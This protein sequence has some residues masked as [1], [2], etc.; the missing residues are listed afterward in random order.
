MKS[1]FEFILLVTATLLL[2]SLVEQSFGKKPFDDSPISQLKQT[3]PD[4][5]FMGS[6]ILETRIN[7]ELF[8][9]TLNKKVFMFQLGGAGMFH[10]Y[11]QLTNYI[12]PSKVKPINIFIF[13][14][15]HFAY[16]NIFTGQYRKIT[17]TLLHQDEPV[18]DLITKLNRTSLIH[19]I[20]D[21]IEIIYPIQ[22]FHDKALNLFKRIAVLPLFRADL[23]FFLHRLTVPFSR[24]VYSFDEQKNYNARQFYI[25]EINQIFALKNLRSVKYQTNTNEDPDFF[26]LSAQLKKSF[27]P[28]FL[29]N[30]KNAGLKLHFIQVKTRP[31]VT[32]ILERSPK[33][34]AYI[35]QLQS[36]LQSQGVSFYDFSDDPEIEYKMYSDGDHIDWNYRDFT[37]QNFIKRLADQL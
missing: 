21:Q 30:A 5:I 2:P 26:D 31:S 34:L 23:K 35:E 16:N 36:Y 1:W 37:T 7:P 3:Q 24:T 17:E 10:W 11:A 27:L 22:N 13:T 4:Y 9:K 18:Y 33:E 29:E 14:G 6:S 25:Q 20:E 19:K 28:H 12:I 15:D 8:E 32:G